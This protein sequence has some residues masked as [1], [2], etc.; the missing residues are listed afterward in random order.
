MYR[1]VLSSKRLVC[2][3]FLSQGDG[4]QG[5]LNTFAPEIPEASTVRTASLVEDTKHNLS[6]VS[7]AGNTERDLSPEVSDNMPCSGALEDRTF[8]P[9]STTHA[10]ASL[11]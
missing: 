5:H 10:E 2:P 9:V 4:E 11:F 1:L 6:S 3:R 7:K 8:I